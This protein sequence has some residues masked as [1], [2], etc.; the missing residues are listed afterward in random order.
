MMDANEMLLYVYYVI[1]SG[2]AI[3][4]VVVPEAMDK[5][6]RAMANEVAPFFKIPDGVVIKAMPSKVPVIF[7]L[8]LTKHHRDDDA[9]IMVYVS[10]YRFKK[11]FLASISCDGNVT[12][13]DLKDEIAGNNITLELERLFSR[14]LREKKE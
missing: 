10:M 13:I 3:L 7:R 9:F 4:C 11:Q 2:I 8:M 1:T 14:N 5:R 6:I 12:T